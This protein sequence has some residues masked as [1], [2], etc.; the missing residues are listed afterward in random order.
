MW[1]LDWTAENTLWCPLFQ[2]LNTSFVL[3]SLPWGLVI[4]LPAFFW[5]FMPKCQDVGRP[6]APIT[7]HNW[8]RRGV[9]KVLQNNWDHVGSSFHYERHHW[10]PLADSCIKKGKEREKRRKEHKARKPNKQKE[11]TKHKLKLLSMG[12]VMRYERI[13][14][15]MTFVENSLVEFPPPESTHDPAQSLQL[16]RGILFHFT[17]DNLIHQ[18]GKWLT[19]KDW[20]ICQNVGSHILIVRSVLSI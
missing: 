2:T 11:K 1:G 3:R 8:Y 17:S 4:H 14:Y 16:T 20:A 19:E 7:D 15:W 18:E 10:N 13:K 9:S 5:I 6:S 12:K